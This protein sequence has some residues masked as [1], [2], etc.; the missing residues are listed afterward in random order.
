MSLWSGLYDKTFSTTRISRTA[1][2]I[3]AAGTNATAAVITDQACA[4]QPVAFS[5]DLIVQG[6]TSV[7]YWR[8]FTDG[9]PDVKVQDICTISGIDYEVLSDPEDEAGRGDVSSFLI[10]SR[11]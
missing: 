11:A 7:R 6:Q 4:V 10:G 8:V 9:V 5:E 3:S 2:T 1:S